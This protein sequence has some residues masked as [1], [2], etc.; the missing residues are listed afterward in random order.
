MKKKLLVVCA[1]LV[2]LVGAGATVG[3]QVRLDFDINDPVYFGYAVSGSQYGVWNSSPYIPLPDA[4]LQFQIPLGPLNIGA[5][6]RVFTVI[7]ENIAYPEVYAELNLDKLVVNASV[8]GL[9]FLTFGLL[10]DAIQSSTG[11][12][13]SGYEPIVLAD[14]SV[15]YKVVDFFRISAGAFM[16]A[17]YQQNIGGIFDAFA[18]AGYVKASFVVE[19]K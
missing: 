19:F 6:A 10:T 8:G 7:V 12:V 16:A 4:R 1:A 17:P 18:F 3:A 15:G 13:L 11:A 9:E 5:G 14:V 2:M